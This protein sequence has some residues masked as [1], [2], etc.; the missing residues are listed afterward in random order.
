M[1]DNR[2]YLEQVRHIKS[3]ELQT[4]MCRMYPPKQ[5]KPLEKN[6]HMLHRI[7][8]TRKKIPEAY[9]QKRSTQSLRCLW[10][11]ISFGTQIPI[12]RNHVF[13]HLRPPALCSQ[14]YRI[15]W[16]GYYV[17]LAIFCSTCKG[18]HPAMCMGALAR[19][20]E[21]FTCQNIASTIKSANVRIPTICCWG[22]RAEQSYLEADTAPSGPCAR[23]KPNS[24]SCL[25][26][27]AASLC[28]AAFVATKL[29]KFTKQRSVVSNIWHMPIGP[30][31][32]LQLAALWS[33]KP[34]CAIKVLSGSTQIPPWVRR[35][36]L[37]CNPN[38]STTQE[39]FRLP[40]LATP[41]CMIF[42]H[43]WSGSQLQSWSNFVWVLL[44]Q[45]SD[46]NHFLKPTKHCEFS[47]E[48]ILSKEQVE[49]RWKLMSIS[50]PHS[51]K[52]GDLH[53]SKQ[54]NSDQHHHTSYI[55]V[56]SGHTKGSNGFNF[57]FSIFKYY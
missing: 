57:L 23:L 14:K 9:Q 38:L 4:S 35:P 30:Y 37:C 53:T 7:S 44:L 26:S 12:L 13:Y 2:V 43:Q 32:A 17:L 31:Y 29:G 48:R 45:C 42:D 46:T 55:S 40:L 47:F 56:R 51:I 27:P 36:L 20:I 34:Q 16:N 8:D 11:P 15:L 1:H 24:M 5:Q 22:E 21:Y 52:H 6:M 41:W 39:I 50:F 33:N 28:L 25:S 19:Y 54:H 18:L 10:I 49:D 3:L